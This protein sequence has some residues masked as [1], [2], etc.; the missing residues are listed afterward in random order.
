MK[1]F[2]HLLSELLACR[3][4]SLTDDVIVFLRKLLLAFKGG[5]CLLEFCVVYLLLN[6]LALFGSKFCSIEEFLKVPLPSL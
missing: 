4:D 6:S 3:Y 5:F 2:A 1:N